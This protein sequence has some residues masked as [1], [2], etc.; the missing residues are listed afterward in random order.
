MVLTHSTVLEADYSVALQLLLKY[1][2]PEAPHGPHTFVDDAVY[3]KDHLNFSGGTNLIL[4]NAH[5]PDS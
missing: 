4:K 2:A 3:L 1:P 5:A